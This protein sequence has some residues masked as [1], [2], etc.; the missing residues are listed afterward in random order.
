[1]RTTQTASRKKYGLFTS[2]I[3][4]LLLGG[5][6][7]F[8]GSNSSAIRD[9]GVIAC[10]VSVYLIRV[11]NVHKSSEVKERKRPGPIMWT[12]GVALLL[13][14]VLSFFY[15]RQDASNGYQDIAPVYVF[16]GVGL[17]CALIWSYL[18]SKVL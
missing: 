5:A 12:A 18:I 3:L 10:I 13:L 16:A 17:G 6:A 4:L 11:S 8:L 7:L 9:V 1:M 15:L 2:A 14:M